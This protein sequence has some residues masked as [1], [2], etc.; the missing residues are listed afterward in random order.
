MSTFTLEQIADALDVH[1]TSAMRRAARESWPFTETTG[2][3]GKKRLY[4]PENLPREVRDAILQR[5]VKAQSLALPAHVPAAALPVASAS[6]ALSTVV[7]NGS[8]EADRMQEYSAKQVLARIQRIQA[9]ASVSLKAACHTLITSARAGLLPPA[10]VSVL[11]TAR[12]ARGRQ[13]PDGLPSVR[14]LLR[15]ASESENG[16]SMLPKKPQK[17]MTVQPW[18]ALA[19]ALKQR[20]QKPKTTWIHEQIKAQWNPA[21]GSEPPSY[22]AVYRFFKDKFSK[23]EQ[24]KGQHQGSALRSHLFYQH[25]KAYGLAPFTEVHADGWNTHFKAPHPVTGEFVTHEVWHF[26]DIA[27]RYV[28][29]VSIGISECFEVIAKGLENCIRV[30][31]VMCIWQTDSTGSVKN[32]RMELDPVASIADRAGL[33]VVHPKEV[34]NSQANGIAENFNTYLDRES[35]ELATYQGKDMD[36]LALKRVNKFTTAMVR[37]ARNGDLAARDEAK[38]QASLAG[39]GLVFESYAQMVDWLNAKVDKFNNSPH[40]A[41]PKITDP[42]TG[43][44]RHQTPAEALEEARAAGWQP[45]M[46]EEHHLIDLFRPHLRKTVRRGTV[47]PFGGQRYYHSELPHIEGEEVMV[48]VDIMDGGRVWVKDL[49]GRLICCAEFVEATG[50]RAQSMYE[51]AQ[52]KRL[53]AQVRRRENDID[54]IKDRMAPAIE[55]PAAPVIDLAMQLYANDVPKA[56]EAVLAPTLAASAAAL[57]PEGAAADL[58]RPGVGATPLRAEEKVT[59]HH[60]ITDLAMYLYG[61]A[62]EEQDRETR[63]AA[64]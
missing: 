55:A 56:R 41:L 64:R 62:I 36:S 31:G 15:W 53:G 10:L 16:G 54:A 46:L 26:H 25:R 24:L 44:R 52:E 29:P 18:Y 60:E 23:V 19:I 57:P 14:S 21:W 40:S 37:A 32:A 20:P 13:S 45:V 8:T 47:S 2:L 33:T 48:A 3:G 28:T 34:G 17:D 58:G 7:L 11:R 12:D 50:Y 42:M 49:N 63:T 30:G 6:Y 22:D 5:S 43:K 27:T 51:F 9:D 1:K 38:R 59:N 35:R 4:A 61:D 39:R